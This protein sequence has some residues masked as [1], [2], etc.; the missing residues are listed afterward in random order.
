MGIRA[1]G[2][3]GTLIKSKNI[4][5]IPDHWTM[6]DAATVMVTYGTV[7]DVLFCVSR[8]LRF[9]FNLFDQLLI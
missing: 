3:L 9:I 4:L 6:E 8:L 5:P 2:A 1:N 7:L